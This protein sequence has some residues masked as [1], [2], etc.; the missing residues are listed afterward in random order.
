MALESSL[1]QKQ[2]VG[3]MTHILKKY[4]MVQL[5]KFY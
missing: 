4:H 5:E 1:Y 3:L 2:N